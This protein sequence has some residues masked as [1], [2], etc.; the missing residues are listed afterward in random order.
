MAQDNRKA[1]E[2][3]NFLKDYDAMLK[4]LMLDYVDCARYET[5]GYSEFIGKL[6]TLNG[7]M[8]QS[9]VYCDHILTQMML[10][11]LAWFQ[12]PG[13]RLVVG[14]GA[15]WHMAEDYRV[16]RYGDALYVVSAEPGAPVRTGERI[17]GVNKKTLDAIRPEVERTLRT[18]VEPADPEREDWSIVLAFAKHLTVVGLDG[19]ER[20]VKVAPGESAVTERM[21]AY[22]AKRDGA[23]ADGAPAG[24]EGVPEAAGAPAAEPEPPCALRR[25]GRIA[26]LRLADPGDAGFA[27]ALEGVLAELGRRRAAGEVDG[28]VV[29]AR[30]AQGGAQRDIYPLVGALLA[31]GAAAK[32]ADAFGRP[33][34]LMNCSRRNVDVKLAELAALRAQLAAGAD[35]L[36]AED[37]AELDALEAELKEKRGHGLVPDESD[38]YDDA[39]FASAADG[40]A[41]RTVV[42]ADRY[43]SDAAEWLAFAAKRLG[44][45][46]VAGR[47]TAGSLD[48]TCPRVVRLDEDF[49]L[50][51]PTAK[52]LAATEG[53]ATLGRGVVPDVHL[54]WTPEQLERDVE[55]ERACTLAAQRA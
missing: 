41:G 23:G 45:A 49:A 55:L 15:A 54:A 11:Y 29:D 34:I 32:P 24:D 53:Q 14:P 2:Q 30:G 46:A 8:F 20:T 3:R 13:L 5:S 36:A 38:Y 47:A 4:A 1:R 40:M 44:Y 52:Y 33:G 16:Q 26:V 39:S 43:T 19:V 9:P 21:K 48:N 12:D 31:P 51:V 35:G 18:T 17:V 10:H 42:L 37:A 28:L 50:V 6:Y 7:G 27:P 25:A 22:Y